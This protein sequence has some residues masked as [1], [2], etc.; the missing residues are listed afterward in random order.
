LGL[1][2]EKYL[3][4]LDVPKKDGMMAYLP[5]ILKLGRKLSP[6]ELDALRLRDEIKGFRTKWNRDFY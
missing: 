3:R 2:L 1:G 6:L 4:N 5:E